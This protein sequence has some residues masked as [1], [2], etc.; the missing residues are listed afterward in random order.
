MKK[1]NIGIIGATGLAGA[2]LFSILLKHPQVNKI[3]LSSEHNEGVDIKTLYPAFSN[4]ESNVLISKEELIEKSD[5]IFI[6]LPALKSEEI[7]SKIH[8]NKYVID[9]GSDFR[10]DFEEEYKKWYGGEYKYKELHKQKEYAVSEICDIYRKKLVANPGCYPTSVILGIYP[11]LKNLN[12]IDEHIIIDSKS[13]ISGA[14]KSLIE[15]NL[16][17]FCNEAFQAYKVGIHRHTAEIEQ[18]INKISKKH[19]KVTFTP[20]L[21]PVTR[22]IEST[23]YLRIKGELDSETIKN[24][25]MKEYEDKPFIRL[26]NQGV[27]PNIKDVRGTNY[28]DISFHYDKRTNTL[29]VMTAID[30]LVKGA[31]GQAIQNMNKI[32]G[33]EE[34]LGLDFL[35]SRVV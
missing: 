35:F 13:G 33:Y 34:T 14:G 30:N 6:S 15:N 7:V 17:V 27:Y 1:I 22:G 2:E 28:C 19:Y 11:I 8:E 3:Y 16:F 18:E 4:L 25:Y 9:L 26:L 10:L 32:F 23:I 20:H 31:A 12:N 29:I 21:L 24:L 5:L